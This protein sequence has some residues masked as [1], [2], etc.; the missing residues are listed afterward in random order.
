MVMMGVL[1]P[2]NGKVGVAGGELLSAAACPA[3]TSNC[4]CSQTVQFSGKLEAES[5]WQLA[6]LRR[7]CCGWISD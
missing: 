2:R 7:R 6:L 4:V 1:P 3:L 5:P